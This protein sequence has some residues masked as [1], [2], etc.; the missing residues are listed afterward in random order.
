MSGS[1]GSGKSIMRELMTILGGRL[2]LPC[3]GQT[4]TE[5]GLR[6]GIGCDSVLVA[7]DEI[8]KSEHRDKIIYFIRSA[9]R[10]GITRKGSS[11]QRAIVAQLKHMVFMGSVER[12]LYRAAENSRYLT[13]ETKKSADCQPKFPSSQE[14]E[15]LREKIV[16]YVIWAAFKAKK[17]VEDVG[18]IGDSDPRFIESLAVAFSMIAIAFK[19]PPEK[20]RLLLVDYL[21]EWRGRFSAGAMEDEDKLIEDIMMARIRLPEE[22]EGEMKS[23]GYDTTKT[24]YV[25]RTVSQLVKAKGDMADEPRKVLEAHGLKPV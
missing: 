16:V 13:I 14:A 15:K 12:G 4:L 9:G 10:G 19:D 7:I 8:E 21:E 18:K 5:P 11:G 17:L 24:V 20:M 25:T 2:A 3:E 6:Q 1:S 22:V 23:N